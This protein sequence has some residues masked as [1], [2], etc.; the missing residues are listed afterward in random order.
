MGML[1]LVIDRRG[2]SLDLDKRGVVLVRYPDGEQHRLG[3][4]TLATIVVVGKVALSSPLLRACHAAGVGL[5]LLPARGREPPCLLTPG[6]GPILRWRLAQIRCFGDPACR[7]DLARRLVAAKLAA[8]AGALAAV[9]RMPLSPSLLAEVHKAENHASLMGFEGAAAAFYFREWAHSWRP[10][11]SFSGRTRRPP[12]DPINALLSLGY[13]LAAQT[14]S[15]WTLR[16]GLDLQ[17]GFLHTP[18]ANRDACVLDL[19]EPVRPAVDAWTRQQLLSGLLTP[20]HFDTNPASG[21]RLDKAGRSLFFAA[22]YRELHQW[23]D[24]T[25]RR[26]LSVVLWALRHR[27]GEGETVLRVE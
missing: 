23:L 24:P 26:A 12:R 10:P 8:Q 13:T 6:T 16:Y 9:G 5:V 11:W 14:V 7:L 4:A 21:C 19:L 3:L 20:D 17:L 1:T 2:S 15:H 25:V 18:V 22:W 27:M